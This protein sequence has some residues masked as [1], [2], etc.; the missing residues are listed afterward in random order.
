MVAIPQLVLVML[1]LASRMSL[2]V[3]TEKL[4]IITRLL[5]VLMYVL[6]PLDII[7]N[8]MPMQI[9]LHL[10]IVLFPFNIILSLILM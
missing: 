3:V 6:I 9:A 2:H 5:Q 4:I 10:L 1:L 8:L 7:P